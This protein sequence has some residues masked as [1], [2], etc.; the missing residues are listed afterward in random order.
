MKVGKVGVEY[1]WLYVFEIPNGQ[2]LQGLLKCT[3]EG[4]SALKLEGGP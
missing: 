1:G 3:F 2:G 4:A